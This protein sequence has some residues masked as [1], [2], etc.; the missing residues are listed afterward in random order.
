MNI[1]INEKKIHRKDKYCKGIELLVDFFNKPNYIGKTQ[2]TYQSIGMNGGL[3]I[4]EAEQ[5]ADRIYE[6]L[7]QISDRYKT[8][9]SILS[10]EEGSRKGALILKYILKLRGNP[11]YFLSD[12][13]CAKHKYSRF[14]VILHRNAESSPH[15]DLLYNQIECMLGKNKKL[16]K[17]L[18]ESLKK[19]FD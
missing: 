13:S 16:K 19:E 9:Y 5:L 6:A 11:N 7:S 14:E 12:G 10:D 18:Y 8:G 1:V 3:I 15:S 17:R 2:I 4:P